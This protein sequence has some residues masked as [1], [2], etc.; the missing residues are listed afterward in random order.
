MENIKESKEDFN[1]SLNENEAYFKKYIKINKI[2]LYSFDDLVYKE[3]KEDLIC[4]ICFYILNNPVSCSD[5][6]NSHS[7]CK[8]CI[9]NYLK[10]NNK[11]P[12]CKL[13]FQYK[14]NNEI[15]MI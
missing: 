6:N 10:E 15:V 1:L 11:C 13:N 4:P 9:D 7:F 12:T 3:N 2:A 14:E 8:E 5:K